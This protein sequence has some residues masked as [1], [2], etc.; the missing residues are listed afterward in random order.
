MVLKFTDSAVVHSD[1]RPENFRVRV[2]RLLPLTSDWTME[3]TEFRNTVLG[4]SS[5]QE[6]FVYCS[7]CDDSIARAAPETHRSGGRQERLLSPSVQDSFTYQRF[8]R[9]PRLYKGQV[10]RG[11]LIL[12][13]GEDRD[14]RPYACDRHVGND[15]SFSSFS[16]GAVSSQGERRKLHS[17]HPKKKKTEGRRYLESAQSLHDSRQSGD[18]PPLGNPPNDARGG[19]PRPSPVGSE[20]NRT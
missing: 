15:V 13:R 19:Q 12:D 14:T 8:Q 16:L 18:Q 9:H 3:L 2:P 11:R 5:D 6:I 20:R 17:Q 4:K 1:N 7:V 10:R